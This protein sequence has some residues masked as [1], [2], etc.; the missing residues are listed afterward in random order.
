MERR[1]SELQKPGCFLPPTL[2]DP[3]M[4]SQWLVTTVLLFNVFETTIVIMW[5][6]ISNL[7]QDSGVQQPL[8]PLHTLSGVLGGCCKSGKISAYL[9][10]Y[11]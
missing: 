3:A 6:N 9:S 1:V 8:H 2:R 5:L 11:K 10:S 4:E 7:E